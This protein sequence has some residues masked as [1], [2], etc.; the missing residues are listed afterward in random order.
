MTVLPFRG[1]A[2]AEHYEVFRA[3][4]SA[5]GFNGTA[6]WMQVS[7]NL[8]DNVDAGQANFS[9]SAAGFGDGNGSWVMRGVSSQLQKGPWSNIFTIP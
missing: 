9:V 5:V 4:A 6:G 7:N 8:R 2:W 3:N 1:A